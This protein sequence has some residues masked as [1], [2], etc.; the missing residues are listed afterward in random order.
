[1]AGESVD[2]SMQPMVQLMRT[3]LQQGNVNVLLAHCRRRS[4]RD[5]NAAKVSAG[6]AKTPV[7]GHVHANHIS[8]LFK[9]PFLAALPHSL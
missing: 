1:M 5:K 6:I 9:Q 7:A 4:R 3:D 8:T 2:L